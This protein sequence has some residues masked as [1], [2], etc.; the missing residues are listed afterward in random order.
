MSRMRPTL[1]LAAAVL[2]LFISLPGVANTPLTVVTTHPEEET[3]YLLESF[4]QQY[5]DTQVLLINR[6]ADLILRAVQSGSL[7]NSDVILSSSPFLMQALKKAGLLRRLPLQPQTSRCAP[8][9]LLLTDTQL[10][11]ASYGLAGFGL[12][13]KRQAGQSA[14]QQWRTLLAAKYYGKVV[15]STPSRSSSTHLMIEKILQDEGWAAGW[16]LL[17]QLGG[18]QAQI[19]GRSFTVAKLLAD[20]DAS[21]GPMLDNGARLL[22]RQRPD[23]QFAYFPSFNVMPSYIGLLKHADN[24]AP[25]R[26]LVSYLFSSKGQ[27]ELLGSSRFK[28][29]L[30]PRDG[31]NESQALC[32]LMHKQKRLDE[33]QMWQREELV[34]QLYDTLITQHF[35]QLRETWGLIRLAESQPG[36]N[37]TARTQLQTAR[38]LASTPTISASQAADPVLLAHFTDKSRHSQTLRQQWHTRWQAQLAEAALLARHIVAGRAQ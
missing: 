31:D 23:L 34:K 19:A 26:Q 7:R 27:N 36:L 30:N 21:V 28:V 29:P 3:G 32:Q 15:I 1:S 2:G 38:Q 9:G 17:L 16:Q 12:V 11:F 33:T 4:R 6:R 13:S 37:A 5:P 18:Q 20:G 35:E 25:A 10:T 8:P 24:Q 14:P 22:V